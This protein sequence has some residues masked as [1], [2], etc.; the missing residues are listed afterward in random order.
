MPW[1]LAKASWG[2]WEINKIKEEQQCNNS[3][4]FLTAN[5]LQWQPKSTVSINTEYS[6]RNTCTQWKSPHQHNSHNLFPHSLFLAS[7]P[8]VFAALSLT[9]RKS[10][11]SAYSTTSPT[12]ANDRSQ[13]SLG[14]ALVCQPGFGLLTFCKYCLKCLT[15]TLT[16]NAGD[17]SQ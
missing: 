13:R 8:L 4:I 14:K 12:F 2:R 10:K 5:L 6:F 15:D 1:I 3:D 9:P 17:A 16:V 7:V 11:D